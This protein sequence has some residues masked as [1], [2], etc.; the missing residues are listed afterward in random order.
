MISNGHFQGR[1]RHLGPQGH[2]ECIAV[3]QFFGAG[4]GGGLPQ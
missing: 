4:G 2:P 1:K 3:L